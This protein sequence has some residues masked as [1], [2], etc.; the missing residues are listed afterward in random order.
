VLAGHTAYVP[1]VAFS[2]DGRTLASGSWDGTVRVWDVADVAHPSPRRSLV[3]HAALVWS[4]AF[5]PDGTTLASACEDG[6]VKLWD[7]ATGRE[8][9]TLVG[10]DRA[11]RAVAWRSPATGKSWP[12]ATKEARSACG[13]AEVRR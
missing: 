8:R 12:R 11:V 3:G 6:T 9:C 10:H 2:R 4:V 7:P 1:T 5:S 13:A